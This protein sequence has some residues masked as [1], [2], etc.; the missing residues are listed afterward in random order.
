MNPI[1]YIQEDSWINIYNEELSKWTE[2]NVYS[3]IDVSDDFNSIVCN[4]INKEL[5]V[6][7]LDAVIHSKEIF[8]SWYFKDETINNIISDFKDLNIKTEKKIINYCF[9]FS[10]ITICFN[11]FI[12]LFCIDKRT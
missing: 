12:V 6:E 7:I 11:N 1:K 4:L 9:L 2:M 10:M 3:I 5:D 8:H